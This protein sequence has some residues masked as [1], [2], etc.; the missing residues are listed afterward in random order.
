MDVRGAGLRTCILLTAHPDSCQHC[1]QNSQKT[2]QDEGSIQTSLS[3]VSGGLPDLISRRSAT[4]ALPALGQ[5]S[6]FSQPVMPGE[7]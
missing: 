4:I 6:S 1:C 2:C 7:S 3:W 5:N